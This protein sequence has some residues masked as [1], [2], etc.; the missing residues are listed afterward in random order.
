MKNITLSAPE[1]LIAL[2]RKRAV[3]KGTTLNNEF[4]KWLQTQAVSDEERSTR[5]E[6]LMKTLGHID[7]GH[8][9]TREEMNK[10]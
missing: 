2:A 1:K 10:R 9:F 5:Y 3:G 4:R 6:R 7:A 8:K